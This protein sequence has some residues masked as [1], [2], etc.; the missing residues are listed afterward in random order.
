MPWGFRK[1]LKYIKDHYSAK[2]I[3]ITENGFSDFGG[4][5]DWNRTFYLQVTINL[6]EIIIFN[7]NAHYLCFAHYFCFADI[8]KRHARCNF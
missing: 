1:L 3:Y 4:T 7:F 5:C 6:M 8:L 2:D